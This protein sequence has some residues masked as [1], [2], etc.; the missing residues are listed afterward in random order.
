[1]T[2]HAHGSSNHDP[3]SSSRATS[4]STIDGDVPIELVAAGLEREFA[5]VHSM[6]LTVHTPER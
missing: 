6:I 2:R 1:M 3:N 5:W 4:R